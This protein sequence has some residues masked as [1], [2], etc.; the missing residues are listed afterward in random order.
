MT[1]QKS[2]QPQMP[3]EIYQQLANRADYNAERRAATAIFQALGM[4]T[5]ARK[6]AG[7]YCVNHDILETPVGHEPEIAVFCLKLAMRSFHNNIPALRV[8]DYVLGEFPD[9]SSWYADT[10]YPVWSG[11]VT[12]IVCADA[13]VLYAVHSS[14]MTS[15]PTP[16]YASTYGGESSTE[17]IYLINQDLRHYVGEI[18]SEEREELERWLNA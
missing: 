10:V 3:V 13:R 2:K 6:R 9:P 16:F 17:R 4:G 7:R 1:E 18:T 11:N 5:D 15:V 8:S 12:A 14:D